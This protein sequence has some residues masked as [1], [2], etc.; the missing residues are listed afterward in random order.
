VSGSTDSNKENK[1]NLLAVAAVIPTA[2]PKRKIVKSLKLSEIV[3]PLSPEES[4]KQMMGAVKRILYSSDKLDDVKTR[5]ISS[6]AVN[7]TFDVR[8]CKKLRHLSHVA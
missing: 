8:F 5:L 7:S 6:I 4:Q 3:K 2:G 1:L